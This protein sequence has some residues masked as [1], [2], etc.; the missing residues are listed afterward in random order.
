MKA[1]ARK[2]GDRDI[3]QRSHSA[4]RFADSS[5]KMGRFPAINRWAIFDRPLRG[6]EFS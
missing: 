3:E 1:E 6:L 4:V 5:I 2:T